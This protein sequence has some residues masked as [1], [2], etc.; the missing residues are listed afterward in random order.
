MG[1]QVYYLEKKIKIGFHSTIYTFKNYFLI[2]FSVSNF[3]QNKRY[4]NGTG[5]IKTELYFC[6][7]RYDLDF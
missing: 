4:S 5:V 7:V 3:Q 2:V 6:C 1:L